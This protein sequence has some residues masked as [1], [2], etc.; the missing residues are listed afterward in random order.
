MKELVL[1]GISVLGMVWLVANFGWLG[2]VLIL[3]TAITGTMFNIWS[4]NRT[5]KRHRRNRK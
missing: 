2:V 3:T 1:A 4:N 5:P